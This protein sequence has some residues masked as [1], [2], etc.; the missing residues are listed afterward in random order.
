MR[1]ADLLSSSLKSIGAQRLRTGLML[2]AMAIG[3]AAVILLTA[4]GEG[5]RRYV[6]GEFA[7]L[8]TNLL[9][10]LPGRS[11]TTGGHPPILG[12]TSRDL[13][14]DDAVAL[15]RSPYLGRM[16]PLTI[17]SAPVAFREREREANILGSTANLLPI[18]HL[19][20]A[21]GLFLPELDPR[22][23]SP[24]CVLGQV[25]KDEL[26]G[27]QP[28][29]G[30]WLRIGDRRFRVIGIL[31]PK[32]Q[33]IGVEFDE[34]VIIPVAS[35][36]ALFNTPSLFRILIEAK[37]RDALAKGAEDIHRIIQARHEGEDD[38][39]VITQDSVIAT[40]DKIL[41]ALTMTVGGIA[42][43]SLGVAGVLIMNVMLVTVSQRTAEIGLIKAIG[44]TARLV[45]I[46]FLTEALLLSVFGA[47]LG[48]A[49]GGM[50]IWGLGTIYPD[51]PIATPL[52]SPIAAAGVAL[53]T[54]LIFGVLP[55]GRAAR[56]DP[57]QALSR[58]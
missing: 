12:E 36:Q 55:A 11:E 27:G 57:V 41:G 2:T 1:P 32:G 17:G 9:A 33:S 46:L 38:V 40:F 44:A 22:Q 30:Q 18:R 14:L 53:G 47:L 21:Q 31:A 24:V 8:G 43:I 16:A 19:D 26:F 29:L 54:G 39:T 52:W 37:T 7:S 23:A 4:L 25:L 6:T 13:T 58:R 49:L 35:A 5:A 3:V 51:F 48:L 15:L 50:G 10:V 28:A 56:L 20:M 45:R 42:A 34:T